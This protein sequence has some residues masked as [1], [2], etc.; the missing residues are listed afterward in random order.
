MNMTYSKSGLDITKQFEGCSLSAYQ[1][2]AGIWTIG[3]G[4]VADVTQGQTITQDEADAL[5]IQDMQ[6][7]VD[8]VNNSVIAE[9][10]QPEF[11]ALV[12]FVFNVGCNGFRNSTMLRMLNRG[13]YSEAAGQFRHWEYAGGKIVA[14]LLRRRQAEA[15]EFGEDK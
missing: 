10:T 8:C 1:D 6:K 2:I 9:L 15:Q 13:D 4:H 14:G 12:D 7:A 11:D 3:Y 5:L